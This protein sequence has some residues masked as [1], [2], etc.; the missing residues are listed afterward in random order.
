MITK[1][2][3]WMNENEGA[4]MVIITLAYVIATL[5]ICKFNWMSARASRDQIVASQKQQEQNSG[6]QLYSIRS[7]VINRIWK[8]QFE[9]V[10]WDVHMLFDKKISDEFNA[11]FEEHQKLNKPKN[12]IESFEEDLYIIIPEQIRLSVVTQI[13]NA[14][15]NKNYDELETVLKKELI[16]IN[17]NNQIPEFLGHYIDNLK[18]IDKIQ[19][20]IN[21]KLLELTLEMRKFT[22]G[23]ILMH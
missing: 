21:D 5:F 1:L 18:M 10:F 13:A 9:E 22:Q 11:L 19:K 2:I 3:T 14:K 15:V 4:L 7:T 6:L 8:Y 12:E 17:N 23:S 20:S 16:D